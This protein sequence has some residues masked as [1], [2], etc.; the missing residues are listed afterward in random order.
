MSAATSA[1]RRARS[2]GAIGVSSDDVALVD[3]Q[4]LAERYAALWKEADANRRRTMIRELWAPAGEHVRDP[5]Q[6]IREA[7]RT[8]G[9]EAPSLE[10]RD[11]A[12]LETRVARAYD[13]FVAP[14]E[15]TFARQR[16]GFPTM[17]SSSNRR[18][19]RPSQTKSQAS[20]SKY[21]G[22]TTRAAS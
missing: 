9:F 16:R 22:S 6:E 8:L 15:Q 4:T 13:E 7:P 3:P 10:I 12:A 20:A 1:A 5:P 2:G 14:G 18:R 17:S 19:S 21:S 11:Y